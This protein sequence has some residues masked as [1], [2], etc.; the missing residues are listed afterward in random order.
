MLGQY[1]T[2]KS[3]DILHFPI[4][5][6]LN[7]QCRNVLAMFE[8]PSDQCLDARCTQ[9]CFRS[10]LG[11]SWEGIWKGFL[12]LFLFSPHPSFRKAW[13]LDWPHLIARHLDCVFFCKIVDIEHFALRV[14][15]FGLPPPTAIKP[16]RQPP[17]YIKKPWRPPVSV[18]ARSWWSYEKIRDREQSTRQHFDESVLVGLKPQK[19]Q[20]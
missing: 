11:V 4:F 17:R 8:Q 3:D 6:V 13:C 16:R 20:L 2:C 18:S 19:M 15:I 7:A 1:C 14:A 9:G 12:V 5:P 10:S